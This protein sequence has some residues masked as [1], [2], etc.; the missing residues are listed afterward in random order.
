MI[1]SSSRPSAL[2]QHPLPGSPQQVEAAVTPVV[3]RSTSAAAGRS[4]P[5]PELVALV[6]ALARSEARRLHRRELGYG[7]PQA[8]VVLIVMGAMLAMIMLALRGRFP[9]PW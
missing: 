9:L 6:R 4:A 7:L 5:R 3:L 8:A 2:A 1:S